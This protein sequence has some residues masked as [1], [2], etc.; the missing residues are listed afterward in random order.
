[1]LTFFERYLEDHGEGG[2][3]IFFA[4]KPVI[5][6]AASATADNTRVPV[7]RLTAAI[8]L[9]PFDLG[10][11][12]TLRLYM[13]DD[14]ETGEFKASLSLTRLSGTREAWLRLNHA[15]VAEARRQFLHWRVVTP[16]D[17][18]AMFVETK[19]KIETAAG[20]EPA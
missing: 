20:M 12:Q 16:Q 3:G 15:F 13:P 17:R 14:E 10:V 4:G 18:E 2:S 19:A 5:D 7:P 8:W 6:L 9:K 11:S 1:M